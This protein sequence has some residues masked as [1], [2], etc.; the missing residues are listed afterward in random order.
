MTL[1]LSRARTDP[2]PTRIGP[3]HD[4]VKPGQ[5]RKLRDNWEVARGK[6]RRGGRGPRRRTTSKRALPVI[7]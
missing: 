7:M 1:L 2:D 4:P 5:Y 3:G 6:M